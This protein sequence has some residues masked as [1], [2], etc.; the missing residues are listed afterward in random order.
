MTKSIIAYSLALL[1]VV[2]SG[3]GYCTRSTCCGLRNFAKDCEQ[4]KDTLEEQ[5]KKI[6]KQAET[7]YLQEEVID[8]MSRTLGKTQAAINNAKEEQKYLRKLIKEIEKQVPAKNK[9]CRASP[10]IK[11]IVSPGDSLSKI[12]IKFYQNMWLWPRI[13]LINKKIVKNPNLIYPGQSFI[14]PRK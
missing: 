13:Y 10:D 6:E 2:V 1:I 3:C 9:V 8:E 14:I 7:I 11:Y 4:K 5:K 12:A